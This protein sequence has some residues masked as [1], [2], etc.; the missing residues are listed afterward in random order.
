MTK[1]FIPMRTPTVKHSSPPPAKLNGNAV[2]RHLGGRVIVIRSLPC[3]LHW[4]AAP[5]SRDAFG[6][7]YIPQPS[8]P[9][10]TRELLWATDHQSPSTRRPRRN[11]PKPTPP[12]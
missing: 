9:P 1:R 10:V 3:L 7:T 11:N 4:L 12:I 6:E 8:R 2:P 5:I